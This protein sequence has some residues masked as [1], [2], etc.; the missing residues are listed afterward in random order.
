MTIWRSNPICRKCKSDDVYAS[1]T[2]IWNRM[3]QC[4]MIDNPFDVDL[5]DSAFVP[6]KTGDITG[7]NC[8]ACEDITLFD[9]KEE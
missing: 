9:F 8:N 2:L 1:A 4:W 5:D 3:E 7:G 6:S